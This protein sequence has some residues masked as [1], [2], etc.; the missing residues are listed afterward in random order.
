MV[1]DKSGKKYHV[2][3]EFNDAGK[4]LV[5]VKWYDKSARKWVHELKPK[6]ELI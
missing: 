1:A 6:E 4:T 2:L 5:A 3:G